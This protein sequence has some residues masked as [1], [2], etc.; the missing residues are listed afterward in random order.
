M[1]LHN[2]LSLEQLNFLVRLPMLLNSSL[3]VNR[4]IETA[5]HHLK[6][7]LHAEAATVFLLNE[8]KTELT[9]WALDKQTTSELKGKKMPADKG[10]V[11]SVIKSRQA[12]ICNDVEKDP[13]FFKTI[14]S[15]SK[16]VTRSMICSP[17]ISSDGTILGAIQ[18]L[19]KTQGN[20]QDSELLFLE[21]FS[22]QAALAIRNA[23]LYSQAQLQAQKLETLDRRKNE[24][25]TVLA[26]E[27]RTPLNLIQSSADFL[28]ME[29]ITP[30]AREKT[31][32]TLLSGVTRMMRLVSEIKNISLATSTEI[33]LERTI[34][35]VASLIDDVITPLQSVFS[36]RQIALNIENKTDH[37]TVNVD[38]GLIKVAIKNL[39]NNAVRFTPNRGQVT[40]S[41]EQSAGMIK[42]SISDTGIG[43]AAAELPMIF[44][45]FYEVTDAM[46]HS[47]GTY[48]FKSCGLGLGLSTTK[49]ILDAHGS[50]LVIESEPEKGTTVEF[51]L[52]VA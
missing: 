25:I 24:M 7:Q 26:H 17:I 49:A 8:Q 28:T 47:S 12:I 19:N 29:T 22:H 43:I 1:S 10:I 39:V 52:A 11:G 23:Q 18:V 33:A 46:N 15:E 16:F 27:F 3:D 48:E 20:F 41:A 50:A 38:P 44:E 42:L 31:I 36:D 40:I 2:D 6:A 34:T 51:S 30:T 32:K 4:V 13:R 9:F 5:V 14:D 45:K 21:Q 35:D 37:A